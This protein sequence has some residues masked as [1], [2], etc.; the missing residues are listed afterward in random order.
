M[1]NASPVPQLYYHETPPTAPHS[2]S[3][4][5]HFRIPADLQ[6]ELMSSVALHNTA[7]KIEATSERDVQIRAISPD[8]LMDKAC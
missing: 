8:A 1:K 2:M 3:G 5:Q 7:G 6:H 4:T